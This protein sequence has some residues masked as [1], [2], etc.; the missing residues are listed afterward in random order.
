MHFYGIKEKDKG[1]GMSYLGEDPKELQ[2]FNNQGYG[3]FWCRNMNTDQEHPGK[4]EKIKVKDTDIT[5]YF[6]DMDDGTKNEMWKRIIE[7]PIIP[8]MVIE[9]F[10]GFHVYWYTDQVTLETFEDIQKRLIDYYG[11]DPKCKDVVRVLRVPGFKQWKHQEPFVVELIWDDERLVYT[12]KQMQEAYPMSKQVARTIRD[13]KRTF[14][15]YARNTEEGVLNWD[16]LCSMDQGELLL[17]LSGTDAVGGE[18]YELKDNSNGTKQII[19][20]GKS[21][22]CFINVAGDIIADFGFS[23]N[24]FNWLRWDSYGNQDKDIYQIL[25]MYVPEVFR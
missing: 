7:S 25:R 1:T 19:V 15:D 23:N 5:C 6:I 18:R 21:T 24:V 12:D 20:D 3:I 11:S 14:I 8:S 13:P 22:G 16:R 4:R 2:A 17:R 9:T 10:R